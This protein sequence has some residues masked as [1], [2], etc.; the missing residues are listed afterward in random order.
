MYVRFLVHFLLSLRVLCLLS[1]YPLLHITLLFP[2]CLTSLIEQKFYLFYFTEVLNFFKEIT[3]YVYMICM[4]VLVLYM[5]FEDNFWE[6]VLSLSPLVQVVIF[7]TI[8]IFSVLYCRKLYIFFFTF[9]FVMFWV[10]FSFLACPKGMLYAIGKMS[11]RT[12]CSCRVE[13]TE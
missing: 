8:L 2:L 10:L 1:S 5:W 6:L 11:D 7:K 12:W 4:S 13:G 9:R 3:M